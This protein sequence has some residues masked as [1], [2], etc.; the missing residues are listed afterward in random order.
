LCLIFE[1]AC[2][3]VCALPEPGTD[4]WL[5][6]YFFHIKARVSGLIYPGEFYS[7]HNVQDTMLLE[8]IST[9]HRDWKSQLG[10]LAC[11]DIVP[12]ACMRCLACLAV[13]RLP[14]ECKS[15]VQVFNDRQLAL[16]I[17]HWYND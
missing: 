10:R 8:L 17:G 12:Y 3:L 2:V 9:S 16:S 11:R 14:C 6:L 5:Y 1:L 15:L 7:T 4:R 13:L